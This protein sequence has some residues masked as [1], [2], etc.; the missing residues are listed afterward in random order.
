[1]ADETHTPRPR[2]SRPRR[3]DPNKLATTWPG[4]AVALLVILL[5]T[6]PLLAL[7]YLGAKALRL[8][9]V[10]FDLYDLSLIHI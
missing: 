2:P 7:L 3:S 4:P 1:M 6:A 8:P 9:F 10:P 5:T